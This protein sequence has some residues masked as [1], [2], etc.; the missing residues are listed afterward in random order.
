MLL[1]N[2][3]IKQEE[4]TRSEK[5]NRIEIWIYELLIFSSVENLAPIINSTQGESFNI[6][7]LCFPTYSF[8]AS[9][10]W[11]ATFNYEMDR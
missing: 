10:L 7:K 8:H 5:K 6:V 3:I 4:K 1:M 9:A 2:R 11:Q